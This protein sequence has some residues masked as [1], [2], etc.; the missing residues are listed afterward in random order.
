MVTY[1]IFVMGMCVEKAVLTPNLSYDFQTREHKILSMNLI[2]YNELANKKWVDD[3]ES[4]ERYKSK[5]LLKNFLKFKFHM[6]GAVLTNE[7]K[8]Q[9][10]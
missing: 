8:K 3:H 1:E 7:L 2:G 5:G 4:F 6:V 10:S 9:N